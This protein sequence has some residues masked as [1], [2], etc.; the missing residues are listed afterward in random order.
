MAIWTSLSQRHLP[1]SDGFGGVMN[2]FEDLFALIKTDKLER[3]EK[4]VL[5][6][7]CDNVMVRAENFIETAEAFEKF[8]EEY[9]APN[10]G[11]VFHMKVQ[12]DLLRELAGEVEEHGWRAICWNQTSVNGD[13]PWYG[14]RTELSEDH[15]EYDPDGDN[16]DQRP[17]NI[18]RDKDHWFAW[19]DLDPT[20]Q[21]AEASG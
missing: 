18:D 9:K 5:L 19:D 15:P 6:T 16:E 21:A 1:G 20:P 3:W 12:A 7:T 14:C 17:Y 2:G 8:H 4:I 13:C 10:E 11:K